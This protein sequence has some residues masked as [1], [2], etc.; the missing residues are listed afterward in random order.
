MSK[1]YSKH[2][3]GGQKDRSMAVLVEAV[4]HHEIGIG[5][6]LVMQLSVESALG[7]FLQLL[8]QFADLFSVPVGPA[9]QFHRAVNAL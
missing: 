7:V 4:R 6:A 8:F 5:E 2:S 1:A 3:K 9:V